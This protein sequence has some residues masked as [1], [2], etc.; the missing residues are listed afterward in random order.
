MAG[1]NETPRQKMMGILYLVLLGLAATTVTDHVLDA[2]RNLTVSLKTS[3]ENVK[4]NVD[5]AMSAFEGGKLKN[6]PDRARPV[7]EKA[8]KVKTAI[9]GLDK[10][11]EDIKGELTTAGGGLDPEGDIKARADID[12][13]PRMMVRKGRAKELRA[14]IDATRKEIMAQ[15]PPAKDGSEPQ[16]A[17]DA[18]D[19]GRGKGGVKSSWEESNFGDGIPLTAAITALTKIQADMRNTE[20]EA[21]KKI[22]GEVDKAVINLDQF[23]AVAIAP[24]SYVLVGQQYTAEVFLTASDSKSNPEVSVGGSQL[25]VVNGKGQYTVG[26]SREGD[27]KWSGTVK[28]KMADGTMKE[29][30]TKEQNYTVA[31]PS[32][33]VSPDKMNVFYIGV[34]NPV[35]VSAPGFSKDKI[36][37]SMSAGEISGTGGTY[38]VKVSNPGKVTVTVSGMLDG[39]KTTVLGATE[40]RIKRIPPPRVKF[41][42]KAGGSISVGEAKVQNRIFAVLEDFDFEAAFNIQHFKLYIVKPRA[43][44]QVFE[45]TNNAFTP[46]MTA[47]MSGVISGTRII[48]DD[49]FAT[50][51]DGVKRPLDP[52]TFNI[53]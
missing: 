23:D 9:A 25:K 37:V 49:V 13:S 26:A 51:P 45:S 47:A 39:G 7:W 33:V 8:Q 30:K 44:A 46:A 32:A 3:S 17:L 4:V 22:L 12:I 11:I 36:K 24:T 53:K 48:F 31:R 50:G 20:A 2:F 6:E 41:S 15:L 34:P 5:N 52:I 16:L 14:K 35:S 40:F 38:T 10:M 43:D 27:F 18:K 19:P 28:V 21:I 1:A 42:G 29:Y